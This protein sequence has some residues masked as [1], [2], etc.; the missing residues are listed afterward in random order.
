[1]N[2]APASMRTTKARRG[3]CAK[4]RATPLRRA[5]RQKDLVELVRQPASG[6]GPAPALLLPPL[7]LPPLLLPPLLLLPAPES[8]AG[9]GAA[10]VPPPEVSDSNVNVAGPGSHGLEPLPSD[11]AVARSRSPSSAS[12]RPSL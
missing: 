7:L 6:T 8:V 3:R 5:R 4:N 11:A 10:S 9:G 1:M 2:A 12:E